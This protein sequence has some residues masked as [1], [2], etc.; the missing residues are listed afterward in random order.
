MTTKINLLP[1][2]PLSERAIQCAF[3]KEVRARRETDWR[4]GLIFAVP[5]GGIRG[6]RAAAMMRSEGQEKGV[7]DAFVMYPACGYHGLV[8]EFKDATGR[9]SEDQERWIANLRQAGYMVSVQRDPK[10]ALALVEFYFS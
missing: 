5:N 2:L 1:P 8:I 7:P 6:P 9:L 4:Y 10:T 3:F